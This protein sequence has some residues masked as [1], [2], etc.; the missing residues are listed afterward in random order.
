[1]IDDVIKIWVLQTPP[2]HRS[3]CGRTLTADALCVPAVRPEDLTCHFDE[4]FL[5]PPGRKS[6]AGFIP[7]QSDSSE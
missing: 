2:N 7:H 3:D 5:D 4:L 1:M 6:A